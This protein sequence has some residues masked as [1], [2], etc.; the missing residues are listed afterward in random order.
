MSC[1][2]YLNVHVETFSGLLSLLQNPRGRRG[3]RPSIGENESVWRIPGGSGSTPTVF[4]EVLQEAVGGD[5]LESELGEQ[6]YSVG[7]G[8]QVEGRLVVERGTRVAVHMR[9]HFVNVGLCQSV[10]GR[11][12]G[13]DETEELMV[14]FDAAFLPGGA[15]VAVEQARSRGTVRGVFQRARVGELRSVVGE[16]DGKEA[17][18]QVRSG[19]IP[20]ALIT[21]LRN[22]IP[23]SKG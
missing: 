9:E 2:R 22:S 11:T 1:L 21:R 17:A 19:Q 20:F 8:E 23:S 5:P 10:E 16:Q 14:T 13:Q 18:K 15:G 12:L 4:P 3:S 7:E 6:I